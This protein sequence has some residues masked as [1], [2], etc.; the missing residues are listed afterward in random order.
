[1]LK[2]LYSSKHCAKKLLVSRKEKGTGNT[3]I[4]CG[5][6][7]HIRLIVLWSHYPKQH[8]HGTHH[9]EYTNN[10]ITKL[11]TQTS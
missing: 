8:G 9:Y 6:K 7:L 3:A 2:S 5:K 11:D 10:S 4:L 1:M